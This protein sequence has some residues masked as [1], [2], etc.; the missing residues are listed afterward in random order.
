MLELAKRSDSDRNDIFISTAV[1]IGLNN[2]IVEKD[3]WVCWMLELLFH[4]CDYSNNL[5]FKGGTSLSKGYGLIE[6]FSEDIDLILDWRI[7]EYGLNEPWIKRSN[8][9]QDKFNKMANEKTEIFL[10]TKFMPHLKKIVSIQG[11]KNYKLYIEDSD[12]QTIRFVYPQLFSDESLVQEIRLEIGSLAAWTPL[13]S[14]YISPFVSEKFPNIFSKPNTLVRT[15]DAKRTFWEKA[16]ILHAEAHRTGTKIPQRYSRH[17]Y[18]LFMLYNSHI[19]NEAFADFELL[20][21][22]AI[23]KQKFYHS[24]RS[25]YNEANR[26][27]LK[28]L[29]HEEKI[30]DLIKDYKSMQSMIFGKKISFE[31]ILDGLE[32]MMIEIKSV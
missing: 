31:E 2:A 9:A 22:V 5:S 24:N 17:Y 19:K 6:R 28:L 21:K 13:T 29:P 15:V 8:S 20:Q 10:E 18:D 7:L 25:K 14:R 16:T 27:G 26:E 32:K 3:F 1:K 11:I 30:N 23:F 4:H 12:K